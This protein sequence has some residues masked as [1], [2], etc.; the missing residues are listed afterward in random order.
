MELNCD[1]GQ[2][3]GLPADDIVVGR[4]DRIL[5]QLK[6]R[7]SQGR[8]VEVSKARAKPNGCGFSWCR[9]EVDEKLDENYERTF[10]P[11][12]ESRRCNPWSVNYVDEPRWGFNESCRCRSWPMR[13]I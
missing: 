12:P 7:V 1:I 8:W 5:A 10:T 3:T 2:S 13:S 4:R 11:M 6:R 9:E